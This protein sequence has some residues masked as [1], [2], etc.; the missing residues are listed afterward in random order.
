VGGRKP[1]RR[2]WSELQF[3]S[4]MLRLATSQTDNG[5][6]NGCTG[7]SRHRVQC[8]FVTK[9]NASEFAARTLVVR[10]SPQEPMVTSSKQMF[11]SDRQV[12]EPTASGMKH[13]IGD[14]RCHA[15]HRYLPQALRAGA[16]ELE[17][18]L[19]DEFH[20]DRTDVR[21]YR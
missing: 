16:I 7:A 2:I 15:S 12:A 10:V 18:G 3:R 1:I 20:V 19:V 11:D 8:S 17:I 14:G 21:V 13:G 5:G 6:F 9:V 4:R